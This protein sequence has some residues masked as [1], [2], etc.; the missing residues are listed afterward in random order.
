MKGMH[1]VHDLDALDG[2]ILAAS[3]LR[4]QSAMAGTGVAVLEIIPGPPGIPFA[5][6]QKACSP[7]L[8][9]VTRTRPIWHH[10]CP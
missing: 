7:W 8:Q 1:D 5:I 4:W 9:N 6:S 2:V 3:M 10:S